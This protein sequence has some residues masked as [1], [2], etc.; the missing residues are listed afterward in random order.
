ME[1]MHSSD[2]VFVLLVAW[3]FLR[4]PARG[5]VHDERQRETA[6]ADHYLNIAALPQ[7]DDLRTHA[8]EL[9]LDRAA[10]EREA[11]LGLTALDHPPGSRASLRSRDAQDRQ[12]RALATQGG[13]HAMRPRCCV[14]VVPPIGDRCHPHGPHARHPSS[15]PVRG[16]AETPIYVLDGFL[17]EAECRAVIDGARGK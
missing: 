4:E 1:A 16:D 11:R 8:F 10:R 12:L 6:A 13:S 5:K 7:L 9:P 17:S 15:A 2:G 3:G 14:P